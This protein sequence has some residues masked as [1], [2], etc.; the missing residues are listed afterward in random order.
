MHTLCDAGQTPNK[1]LGITLSHEA[2]ALRNINE[3]KDYDKC[4]SCKHQK[5]R[6]NTLNAKKV[7]MQKRLGKKTEVVA[8]C[9]RKL[10]EVHP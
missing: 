5:A 4:I 3:N 1:D 9:L 8:I 2:R 7:D 10:N 6:H